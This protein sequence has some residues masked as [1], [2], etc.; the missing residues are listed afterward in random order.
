[1]YDTK[2]DRVTVTWKFVLD[3]GI[4]CVFVRWNSICRGTE[5]SVDCSLLGS[6]T[7]FRLIVSLSAT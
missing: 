1:V 7:S 4:A 6:N 3:S 5:P 2:T